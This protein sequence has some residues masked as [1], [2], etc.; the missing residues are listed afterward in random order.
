[1]EIQEIEILVGKDG[2]IEL[3]VHGAKGRKCLE[4]TRELEA[5]LGGVV[6][7]REMT[8]E[9]EEDFADNFPDQSTLDQKSG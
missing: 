4:I 2:K 6:L 1:M 5:A 7:S 8:T 9:A 3:F